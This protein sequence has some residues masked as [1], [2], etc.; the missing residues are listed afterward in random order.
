[1][2]DLPKSDRSHDPSLDSAMHDRRYKIFVAVFAAV[3]LAFA[4]ISITVVVITS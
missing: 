1:M 4:A 3:I 2:T